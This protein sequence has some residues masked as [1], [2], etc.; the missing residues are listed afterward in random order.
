MTK[1]RSR[2]DGKLVRVVHPLIE[3]G[4]LAVQLQD[5]DQGVPVRHRPPAARPGMQIMPGQTKCVWDQR[6]RR[7]AVRPERLAIE[8]QFRIKLSRPPTVQ[9]GAYLTVCN[10]R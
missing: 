10:A 5:R 6:S 1:P 4:T 9:N 7:S 2:R 8:Q 3:E